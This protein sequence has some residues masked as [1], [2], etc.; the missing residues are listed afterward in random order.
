M[1]A[2]GQPAWEYARHRSGCQRGLQH[3]K[4]ILVLL[5]LVTA[6]ESLTLETVKVV[7]ING[8]IINYINNKRVKDRML[9]SLGDEMHNTLALFCVA[10]QNSSLS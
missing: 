8:N 4:N 2:I 1:H 3:A 6:S 7:Q 9:A 5:G 10:S